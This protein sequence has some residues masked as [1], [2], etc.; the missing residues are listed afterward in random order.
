MY[1]R[2]Y[3]FLLYSIIFS[4]VV[5]AQVAFI[6]F[7]N[8]TCP[9][10]IYEVKQVLLSQDTIVKGYYSNDSLA[11]Q[12]RIYKSRPSGPYKVYFPT[13]QTK[14][15]SAFRNGHLNGFWKEFDCSGKLIVSGEYKMGRKDRSWLYFS[16]NKVEVYKNGKANGR[17]R[18]DEGWIPRTLFKYKKSVLIETKKHYPQKNVF[19]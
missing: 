3:L 19:Y 17:W 15:S 18:V 7:E 6:Q 11:Y 4:S 12:Y 10:R 5:Q 1:R 2:I 9:I 14:I 13:G 8:N 16:D